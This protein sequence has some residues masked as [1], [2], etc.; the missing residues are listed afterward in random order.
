[1]EKILVIGATGFIGRHVVHALLAKGYAVRC[2][3]RDPARAQELAAAGCEIVQGDI[4]DGASIRRALEGVRAVYVSVH[5]LFPQQAGAAGQGF[6]EVE[7]S[8]LRNIV[9]ACQACGARRLVYITVMGI[10]ADA[11]SAWLRGRLQAE[12]FL[13]HSGLDVTILRPGQVI[14]V[15]GTGFGLTVNQAKGPVAVDLGSGQQKMCNIAIDDLVYYLVGVLDEPR[16]CGQC[17][18]VGCDDVLTNDQM[19]DMTADVLGRSHPAKIHI[20]LSLVEALTPII[21]RAGKFPPG[22]LKAFL[23]SF[24]TDFVGDPMPI[25]AI[26]PQPLLSYRQALER[27]LA[28]FNNTPDDKAE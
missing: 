17:Y 24:R 2:L 19:I 1:M 16:A 18:D 4:A 7:M 23:E 26:L 27:A 9:N 5:T 3:T 11:P 21:E 15:G 22:A 8:G 10:S 14:G 6:M 13:L 20:P 28:G 12:Q 25:R